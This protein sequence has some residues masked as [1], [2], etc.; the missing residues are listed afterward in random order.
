MPHKGDGET[1]SQFCY[2]EL[3][4]EIKIF[5]QQRMKLTQLWRMTFVRSPRIHT[6]RSTFEHWIR[7]RKDLFI[8]SNSGNSSLGFQFQV[9]SM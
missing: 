2:I 6:T 9:H 3:G 1:N 4:L 5:L 8:K 7:N